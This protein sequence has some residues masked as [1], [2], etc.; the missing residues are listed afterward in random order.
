MEWTEPSVALPAVAT[1]IAVVTFILVFTPKLIKRWKNRCPKCGNQ[2][3][4]W[5]T[6]A[7]PDILDRFSR[8]VIKRCNKC[9][10]HEGGPIPRHRAIGIH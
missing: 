6:S 10:W 2:C 8:G 1:T 4:E 5:N 3:E 7:E 9:G